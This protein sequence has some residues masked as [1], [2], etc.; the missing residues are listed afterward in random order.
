MSLFSNYLFYDYANKYYREHPS[1]PPSKD[2]AMTDSEYNDFIKFLEGKKYDYTDRSEK[3]LLELKHSA[4]KEKHFSAIQNEFA[5]LEK[6]M[7]ENKRQDLKTHREELK[8]ILEGE[9]SARYYY[10]KGR[11]ETGFKYDAEVKRAAEILGNQ[12]LYASILNGEGIYKVIGKPG[13]EQQAKA[14]SEREEEEGDN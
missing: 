4:E 14:N 9:I 11:L 7:I 10:Q 12:T 6:K 5:S 1:I 2:F 8:E 3:K 13:S